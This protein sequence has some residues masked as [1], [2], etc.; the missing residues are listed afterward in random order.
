MSVL[1]NGNEWRFFYIKNEKNFA[2]KQYYGEYILKIKN[3][4]YKYLIKSFHKLLSKENVLECN[5]L[6][7]LEKLV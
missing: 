7:Y 6:K 2:H 1:T 4:N 3:L 5:H